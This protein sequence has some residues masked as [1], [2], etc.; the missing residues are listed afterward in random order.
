MKRLLPLVILIVILVL[1]F[2]TGLYR[3]LSFEQLKMHHQQLSQWKN[4][5]YLFSAISFIIIYIIAVAIS[6]PGV[7]ILTLVGGFLFG[8][9]WGTLYVLI[10]ATIGSVIIFIAAKTAFAETLSAKAGPFLNKIEHGFQQNATSYLLFLRLVPVF[11]FWLINII[12]GLLNVP[13]ATFVIS[14]FIG[15]IPGTFVYVS[16]GN[17]LGSLFARDQTPNLAIIFKPNFQLPLL[18]LAILAI[19]PILYKYIAKKRKQS[20]DQ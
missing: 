17:S 18:A 2:S 16:V 6:L 8:L 19:I 13:I 1:L 20:H 12:A 5:H 3:Y 4:N 10:A 9:W 15:I 14:S 7:T 11:P